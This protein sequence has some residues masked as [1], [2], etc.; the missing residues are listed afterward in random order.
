[1]LTQFVAGEF[2]MSTPRALGRS[3][4]H[5]HAYGFAF[6][7]IRNT[8]VARQL[9]TERT[10]RLWS[11]SRLMDTDGAAQAF[12]ITQHWERILN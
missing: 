5:K 11:E 6:H 9:L 10:P 2:P 12:P 8:L 3:G 1:M 4:S 7:G